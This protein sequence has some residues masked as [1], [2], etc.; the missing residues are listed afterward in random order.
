M[1]FG[2]HQWVDRRR[3]KIISQPVAEPVVGLLVGSPDILRVGRKA[4]VEPEVCPPAHG[5]Q[6]AEPLVGKFVGH[7][8]CHV[9][10]VGEGGLSWKNCVPLCLTS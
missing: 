1:S 2:W 7:D 3:R 6:V 9:L 10:L 5:H 4:L 8:N